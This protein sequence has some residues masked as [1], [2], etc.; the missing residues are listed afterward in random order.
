M[1]QLLLLQL[2]ACLRLTNHTIFP[3]ALQIVLGYLTDSRSVS[4]ARQACKS[5]RQAA[6]A[7]PCAVRVVLPSGVRNMRDKLATLLKVRQLPLF[8]TC[9]IDL[10]LVRVHTAA[11]EHACNRVSILAQQCYVAGTQLYS[12]LNTALCVLSGFAALAST[13][14]LS[15]QRLPHVSQLLQ[16]VTLS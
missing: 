2:F 14:H 4:A 12:S 11:P 5:W 15:L 7:A 16:H 3:F 1:L 8:S 9:A 10:Q 6:A 13:Q